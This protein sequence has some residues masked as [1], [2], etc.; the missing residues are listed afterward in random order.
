[1]SDSL[2]VVHASL[3]DVEGADWEAG[4]R[5]VILSLEL[6]E[7]RRVFDFALSLPDAWEAVRGLVKTLQHQGRA[8]M[9]E[10]ADLIARTL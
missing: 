9:D 8:G 1:M 6:Q 5:A 2:K 7:S 4:G 10:L 3:V